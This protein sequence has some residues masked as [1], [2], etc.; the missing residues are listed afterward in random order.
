MS[1]E[2]IG[3]AGE[4][5][6][7]VVG[8][9]TSVEARFEVRDQDIVGFDRLESAGDQPSAVKFEY[10]RWCG[11]ADEAI[12]LRRLLLE[13]CRRSGRGS[14]FRFV[15]FV[16]VGDNLVVELCDDRIPV[17]T[18][19]LPQRRG[20]LQVIVEQQRRCEVRQLQRAK[21][22]PLTAR[23]KQPRRDHSPARTRGS[24]YTRLGLWSKRHPI[25]AEANLAL[26][27]AQG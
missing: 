4:Q 25:A 16:G 22:P 1:R 18:R 7:R 6:C 27:S 23:M 20:N 5:W 8:D 15:S 14:R 11:K 21:Y 13:L 19:K 12:T 10:E 2:A 9:G 3:K 17:Y 24:A 26:R